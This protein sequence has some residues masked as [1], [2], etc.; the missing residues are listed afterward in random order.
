M[1]NANEELNKNGITRHKLNLVIKWIRE[2]NVSQQWLIKHG[3]DHWLEQ[4]GE[5]DIETS[6]P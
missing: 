6:M 2:A 1:S 4:A 5:F 3:V